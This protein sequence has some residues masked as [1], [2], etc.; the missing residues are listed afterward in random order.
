[1]CP[2]TPK[3]GVACPS[4]GMKVVCVHENRF[5]SDSLADFDRLSSEG[6][7]IANDTDVL[8]SLPQETQPGSGA[9]KCAAAVQ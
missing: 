8:A 4:G 5:R 9:G 3:H 2:A 7:I 6:K 1:M